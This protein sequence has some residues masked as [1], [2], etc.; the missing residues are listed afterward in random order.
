MR[1]YIAGPMSNVPLYNFPAFDE[2]AAYWRAD[3]HEV[4]SP[5]DITRGL[6]WER[7]GRCYDPATDRAEWGDPVT[8]ELFARDLAAVCAADAI[9]VLPGWQDS[10]GAKIETAVACALGKRFV[11]HGTFDRIALVATTAVVRI[12][13]VG[14]AH[15]AA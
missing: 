2:A 15:V 9:V 8:C 11:E 14:D 12:A 5:A 6:W 1:I 4:S 13:K 3:G 10:R 7:Y